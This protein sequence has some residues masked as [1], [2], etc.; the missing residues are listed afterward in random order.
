[1][2]PINQAVSGF[3]GLLGLK[4]MGRNIPDTTETLQPGI[5]Y[6]PFMLQGLNFVSG[7][8][9]VA[10]GGTG[11]IV[12]TSAFN[13]V[14]EGR[15]WI[16]PYASIYMAVPIGEMLDASLMVSIG[17]GTANALPFAI[18]PRCRS[19]SAT[20]ATQMT[21]SYFNLHE[22]LILPGGSR[23]GYVV[24][25]VTVAAPRALTLGIAYLEVPA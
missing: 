8:Q 10:V 15:T 18:G 5:N 14:P 17:T 4:T 3:L 9:N 1:M 11:N 25:D 13:L 24:Y 19:T 12:L 21:S 20:I 16:V 6:F 7:N 22:P 23:F 2:G